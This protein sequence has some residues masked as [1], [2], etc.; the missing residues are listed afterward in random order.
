MF[1]PN[2]LTR[3]V[4]NLDCIWRICKRQK[5]SIII[6]TLDRIFNYNSYKDLSDLREYI[7]QAQK[8]SADIGARI[9][10]SARF[11]K[12]REPAWG[13]TRDDKNEIVVNPFELKI[14]RLIILLGTAGS[15]IAEIKFLIKETGKTD[16]IEEFCIE[17]YESGTT[18][19][20]DICEFLPYPMSTENIEDTFRIYG[21]RK[22]K[23]R[24]TRSDIKAILDS[25]IQH[26]EVDIDNLCEDF[27]LVT[28][29][30]RSPAPV[31]PQQWN[32]VWF[33]P[34][35]GMPSSIKLPPGYVLPD[36]ACQV[37]IPIV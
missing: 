29:P 37:F 12:S 36:K 19:V 31:S 27:E 32:S 21:V 5:H 26:R 22:R 30:D 28:S 20:K 18:N 25:K 17:E 4:D 33:D 15:S 7:L 2:R 8:E 35:I 10:R 23:A 3:N 16:G 14:T 9:A 11:R 1:E 13:K 24:W 6:V 34:K